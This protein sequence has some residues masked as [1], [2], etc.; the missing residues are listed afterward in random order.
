MSTERTVTLPT[1][2]QGD[3]TLPEPS[4]CAGHPNPR[5]QYRTDLTHYGPEHRLTF[6]GEPLFAL[7]LAQSPLS[8]RASRNIEAYVEESGYT[9]SLT[10]AGLYDLAAALDQAADHMRVFA[11]QMAALLAGGGTGE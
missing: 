1:I 3:V 10:P 5:P 6:N 4:W 2:D 11:D 9:G 8:E 7:M